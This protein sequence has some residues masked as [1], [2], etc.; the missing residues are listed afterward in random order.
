MGDLMRRR[1]AMLA[2]GGVTTVTW[3]QWAHPMT[4]DYW[5][6]QST[7]ATI[8]FADEIATITYNTD[9][10]GSDTCVRGKTEE[11]R[12]HPHI[13][14]VWYNSF[15]LNPSFG[16]GMWSAEY[17]A[18]VNAI[19]ATAEANVWTRVSSSVVANQERTAGY[20]LFIPS[21]RNT[22]AYPIAGKTSKVKN[23]AL[24]NLTLMY[25]AGNEPTV[26]EFERQCRLNGID[27][28]SPLPRD[29]G[30]LRTWRL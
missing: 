21:L 28:E 12:H 15:M 29:T 23:V 5:G 16:N 1:F 10:G 14:E 24:V 18:I 19:R 3:N 13:G 2:A 20:H 9:A 8:T 7:K 26:D 30:T 27:L 17:C 11:Q 4:A 6:P 25:G 22:S